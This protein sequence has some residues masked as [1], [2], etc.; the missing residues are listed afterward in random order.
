MTCRLLSVQ[1]IQW[2]VSH[3]LSLQVHCANTIFF[4]IILLNVQFGIKVRITDTFSSCTVMENYR[5]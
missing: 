3:S 1:G 2:D 4:M 5:E